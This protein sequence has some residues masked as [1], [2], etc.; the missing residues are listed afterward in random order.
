MLMERTKTSGLR[1]L[2]PAAL[3]NVHLWWE[4]SVDILRRF[5]E[6]DPT[7]KNAWTVTRDLIKNIGSSGELP[8]FPGGSYGPL[9][10]PLR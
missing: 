6:L 8:K 9:L 7:E 1:C 5:V 2:T 4:K 3:H 10:L